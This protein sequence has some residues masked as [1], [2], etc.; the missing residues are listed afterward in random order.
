V[1]VVV[2]GGGLSGL[3]AALQLDGTHDAVVLES[4]DVAGG[5]ARSL[6]EDGRTLDVGPTGWLEG[7]PAMDRLVA[8]LGLAP[9]PAR[10]GPRWIYADGRLHEAP[11]GPRAMLASKLLTLGQKLRL[12]AE[13]V[14]PRGTED[15]E[16][17]GTFAARRLGAAAVDRLVGPMVNGIF[18][19]DPYQLSL[20]AAFPRMA[21]LERDYRSLVLAML[22]LR[23]G[24]APS[25]RMM[26]LPGG[27]GA[28]TGAM[29]AAL[30]PRLRT[31]VAVGEVR[32]RPNGFV[33]ET[34]QGDVE[35]DAVLL[36]SPAPSQ[37]ASV[38]GLAPDAAAALDAIPYSPVAVVVSAWAAGSFPTA[39]R[40]F[41]AL[42]AR[43]ENVGVL[44]T[45]F[46]S[47]L[48]PEQALPGE[49]LLRTLIGGSGDPEVLR[50]D[51]QQ[52]V[53]RASAANA[54]FF[55]GVRGSPGWV[56][57]L[58]HPCAIPR[59]GQGHLARVAVV[60]AAE[61]AVPGLF[62]SG[63]HLDGVG[64]RDIARNAEAVAAR[65]RAVS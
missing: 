54:R 15:D 61:A 2:V 56:R 65:V 48:I 37:A 21:E 35:A 45:L 30:G 59:Y 57:V 8:R 10:P 34:N 25:G 1:R 29:A 12:L 62:F 46:T 19:C 44:G 24:G 28:L 50:M 4:A 33:V 32:R 60:R 36:A 49:I 63:N 20:R 55:G 52:L 13:V 26:S 64:M 6:V 51:D 41:G 14:M 58:R 53:G 27:V 7:E 18:A 5:H 16:T 38:R 39:P 31:G 42:V 40:G 17:V 43:G 3:S 11:L 23:R 22:R 47:E 9:F